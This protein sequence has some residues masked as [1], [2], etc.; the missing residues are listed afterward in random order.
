MEHGAGLAGIL[1][2]AW[3]T[4]RITGPPTDAKPI[5]DSRT[6]L[7]VQ[8]ALIILIMIV[9][10][11][12]WGVLKSQGVISHRPFIPGWAHI[13]H[14]FGL[15]A[16]QIG[17]SYNWGAN[18]VKYCLL[19]L[20]VFLVPLTGFRY[21]GLRRGHRT[22]RV[23]ILWCAIP[24]LMAA[25]AVLCGNRTVGNYVWR[26]ADNTMQ[27]GPWEEFLVRGALQTRLQVLIS[28]IW[29]VVLASIAFGLWHWGVGF[30]DTGKQSVLDG[31][32]CAMVV[33][34]STGIIYGVIYLRTRNLVACSVFHVVS[35]TV[36]AS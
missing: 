26:V 13:A 20:V 35:N 18:P 30:T 21:L 23:I 1:V 22:V 25:Y 28:P 8:V 34:G 14:W 5:R 27:N 4:V 17:V 3:I 6:R 2:F 9:T 24:V 32:A 19:P 12:G 10:G 7:W 11:S 16:R 31:L 33:Q 36:F 15:M 29:G